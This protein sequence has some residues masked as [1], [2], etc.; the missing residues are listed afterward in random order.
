MSDHE[1]ATVA[2]QLRRVIVWELNAQV[3]IRRPTSAIPPLIADSLFDYFDISLK[4]GVVLP[5]S[6]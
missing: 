2:D 3:A 1:R 5:E 4:P 6:D